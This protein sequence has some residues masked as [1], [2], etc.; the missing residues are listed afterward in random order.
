MTPEPITQDVRSA[1]QPPFFRAPLIVVITAGLLL[2]LHAAF[3]M[4]PVSVQNDIDANFAL[5]PE[6]FWAPAGSPSVYPDAASGLL[7]LLSSGL[8]HLDW[9]HVIVNALMLLAF[10]TPVA[11]A[12]GPGV[13]GAG[14]WMLLFVVSVLGGSAL[15]LALV[16]AS[17]APMIGASGGVSGLAAAAFLLDRDGRKQALWSRPFV[18]MTAAFALANVL[19]VVTAPFLLGAFV[20]WEAHAGGYIAGALLMALLPARGYGWAR[21]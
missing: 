7:T 3:A 10:G 8:L 6:R 19:L 20:A 21:S 14:A 2:G 1:K 18:G 9:F 5:I 12:L 4:S 13:A 11:R 15:Y 17:G 16:D